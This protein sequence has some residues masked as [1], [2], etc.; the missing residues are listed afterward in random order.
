MPVRIVGDIPVVRPHGSLLSPVW[1]WLVFGRHEPL[2]SKDSCA[3]VQQKMTAVWREGHETAS[4]LHMQPK[5][6][7]EAW[8]RP[9]AIIDDQSPMALGVDEAA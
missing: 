4:G 9:K 3:V 6:F 7:I 2:K 8:G 5:A 1:G